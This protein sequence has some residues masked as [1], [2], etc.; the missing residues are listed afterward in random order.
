MCVEGS[1]D[2]EVE[3]KERNAMTN[4]QDFWTR[5]F[6]TAVSAALGSMTVPAIFSLDVAVYESMV[7]V[8]GTV[9]INVLMIFAR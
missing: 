6:W 7:I 2:Q 4:A 3:P 1:A 5:T 9:V 8:G